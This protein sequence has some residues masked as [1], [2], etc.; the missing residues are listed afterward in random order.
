MSTVIVTPPDDEPV[1]IAEVRSQRNITSTEYDP[2]LQ[3]LMAAS[4]VY[5]ENYTGVSMITRTYDYFLD[6]FPKKIEIPSPPLQ[7]VTT[8]KYTDTDGAQQTL[9]PSLYTVVTSS[10]PGYIVP[11]YNQDWPDIR[12]VPNAVE[13]RFVSGY[14][15]DET[16][17]PDSLKHAM[18]LLIGT[19]HE[20]TEDIQPFSF[21]KI[22]IGVNALLDQYRVWRA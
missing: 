4:R 21:N 17:V 20:N 15:A 12:D 6:S 14:G 19:W 2:E 1:S 16:F 18:L 13:I 8:L 10:K 22:P 5:I 11:A 9:D 3:R 7:S